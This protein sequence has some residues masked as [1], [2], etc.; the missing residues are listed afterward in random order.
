[1]ESS[2]PKKIKPYYLHLKPMIFAGC[3]KLG[4]ILRPLLTAQNDLKPTHGLPPILFRCKTL[5]NHNVL[6]SSSHNQGFCLPLPRKREC[7]QIPLVDG[8]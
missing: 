8:G 7:V 5:H 2:Y 3:S 4:D 1:M 6:C